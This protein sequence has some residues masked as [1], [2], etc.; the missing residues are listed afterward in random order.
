MSSV[1]VEPNKLFLNLA[2]TAYLGVLMIGPSIDQRLLTRLE[3]VL[4]DLERTI[5][6]WRV[7]WGPGIYRVFRNGIP[8]NTM[9]IAE[10]SDRAELTISIAGTNPLSLYSWLAQDFSVQR[11]YRWPHGQP[12]PGAQITEGT[13]R[14]M[15]ALQ[16]MV[17]RQERRDGSPFP[18]GNQTMHEF[19]RG[20]VIAQRATS[21]G[22]LRITVTG[23]SLG[24]ALSPVIALWLED[25]RAVWDPGHA[26]EVQCRAFAGPTPGNR[27]FARVITE[28]MGTNLFRIANDKDVVPRAWNIDALAEIKALYAPSLPRSTTWDRI[29]GLTI[30]NA[31][32]T[33]FQQI[34]LP[35][36][37]TI[38]PGVID[39]GIKHLFPLNFARYVAQATYQH[40]AA[41]FDLLECAMHDDI[42]AAIGWVNR[43]AQQMIM[44]GQMP[45]MGWMLQK[46]P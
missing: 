39:P 3:C 46:D 10:N 25:T 34:A 32:G 16:Q 17:P 14:G 8:D 37:T 30:Y 1:S 7:V 2:F 23:H 4:G 42:E 26:A 22:P 24:G 38:L 36:Q 27:E 35:A 41:Y 18:G 20:W 13:L 29:V 43:V 28:R 6:R 5:G 45:G 12:P 33:D 40:T 15:R 9:Y 11:L 31:V 19:L 44:M 21:Q